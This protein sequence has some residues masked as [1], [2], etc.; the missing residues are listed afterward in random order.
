M[1]TGTLNVNGALVGAWRVGHGDAPA[2]K[3]GFRRYSWGAVLDG[4]DYGGFVQHKS[5]DGAPQLAAL[6]LAALGE[7]VPAAGRSVMGA[8]SLQAPDFD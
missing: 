1:L 3:D 8:D 7:A 4:H 6:V 5:S 2:G